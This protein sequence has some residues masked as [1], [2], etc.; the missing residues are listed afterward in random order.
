MGIDSRPTLRSVS[1]AFPLRYGSTG[2]FEMTETTLDAI[3]VDLRLLLM[4]NHGERV[5]HYDFGANLRPI[6]F[7]QGP[8]L[9]QRISDAIT[10]A[11]DKWMPF[12]SINSM[13]IETSA[14]NPTVSPNGVHID[15]DFSVSGTVL[16]A[17]TGIISVAA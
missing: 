13:V 2:A 15:V 12:V 8:D 1:I 6:L 16:R 4:T 14:D 3:R 7:S 10:S 11:V 17:T 9:K 5:I